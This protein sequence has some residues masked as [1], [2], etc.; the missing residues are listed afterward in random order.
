MISGLGDILSLII[1][2]KPCKSCIE[3]KEKL[4]KKYP[5]PEINPRILRRKK[6]TPK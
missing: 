6:R 2:I 3:R 5:L 4:N 1:P